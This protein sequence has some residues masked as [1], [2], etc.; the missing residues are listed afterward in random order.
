M[1]FLRQRLTGTET[2]PE[3]LAREMAAINPFVENKKKSF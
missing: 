3:N 1:S 2:K